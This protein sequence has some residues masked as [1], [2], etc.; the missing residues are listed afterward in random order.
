MISD[1][2]VCDSD[3]ESDFAVF[4]ILKGC[5]SDGNDSLI[6]DDLDEGKDWSEHLRIGYRL[7]SE[8]WTCD[9][10]GSSLGFAFRPAV[11]KELK[12]ILNNLVL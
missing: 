6:C 10:S 2:E 8:G 9:E 5:R 11:M 3:D 12:A 1:V 4:A 7:I